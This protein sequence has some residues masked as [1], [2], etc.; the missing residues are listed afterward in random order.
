[1][2]LA[3]A[4][5]V[6]RADA[7]LQ[8]GSGHVMRCLALAA[9]LRLEGTNC[10]FVCR[11][12]QGHLADLIRNRGFAVTLLPMGTL[13]PSHVPVTVHDAWLGCDWESDAHQTIAALEGIRPD[14]IVVDHYAL[15]AAWEQAL[16]AHSGA[17]LVID[18]LADRDHQCQLLVDQNLGRDGAHYAGRVSVGCEVLAGPAYALLRSEFAAVRASSLERR[19]YKPLQ[20]LLISLGGVDQSNATGALLEAL[21]ACTL[22]A[23]VRISV[24]MGAAS[25]WLA[26]VQEIAVQM[27]WP[28]QVRANVQDMARLM[29]ESD[30]ALGAAGATSWERCCLGLPS[31][32]LALAANQRRILKALEEA[33]AVMVLG[34]RS[35]GTGPDFNALPHLLQLAVVP[36]TLHRLSAASERIVDGLGIGRV[37]AAIAHHEVQS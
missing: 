8:I 26:E 28:T 16:S 2:T 12:H 34:D 30:L 6:F 1:M 37:L 36:S 10:R 5:V 14:W 24:A 35:D 32:V 27:P 18:D 3:G 23:N 20:H 22:P 33:G 29:S 9:A 19:R 7:S 31:I 25:P 4:T 13:G 11:G 15:E 17:M 21:R